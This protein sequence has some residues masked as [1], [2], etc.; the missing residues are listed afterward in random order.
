MRYFSTRGAGPVSLDEALRQGIAPDGGLFLP[1][2]LPEFVVDDFTGLDTIPGIARVLLK[3]FFE[4]SALDAEL[5]D[6]LDETFGF[7][8]PLTTKWIFVLNPPRERPRA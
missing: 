8:I 6:V 3:P 1:E 2:R 5:E 7:P 4:G